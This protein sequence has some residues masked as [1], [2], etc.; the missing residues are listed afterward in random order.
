MSCKLLYL[1][2]QSRRHQPKFAGKAELLAN[3]RNVEIG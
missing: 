3:V 1:L 2:G